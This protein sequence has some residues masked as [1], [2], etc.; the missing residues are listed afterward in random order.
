[1]PL[2]P[3]KHKFSLLLAALILLVMCYPSAEGHYLE[4]AIV[5]ALGFFTLIGGLWSVADRRRTLV[6]GILLGVPCLLFGST[7]LIQD[8]LFTFHPVS[9]LFTIAFYIYINVHLI[10]AV[11]RAPRV[12]S[13][14]IAGAIAVYLLLGITWAGFYSAVDSFIPGS[15]DV[16]EPLDPNT[17]L[18][19][20]DFIYFSFITI[21]TLGYGDIIPVKPLAR[22]VAFLEAM[23]GVIYIAVFVGRIVSLHT[24]MERSA[25][26]HPE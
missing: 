18:K 9:S 5:F 11:L 21:S 3:G 13:D 25:P 10:N 6:I 17:A 15:F 20:P 16:T 24:P 2:K 7:T 26:R 14:I 19:R 12:T 4:A 1:M 22:S 8:H 23:T